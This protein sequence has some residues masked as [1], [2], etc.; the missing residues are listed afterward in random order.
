MRGIL[1]KISKIENNPI[2]FN[3]SVVKEEL[4]SIKKRLADKNFRLAIVGEFSSGKSTFINALIGKD[5]LKHATV[6]TTATLT[7][8]HNVKSDYEL[9][10]KCVV[11]FVKGNKKVLDDFEELQKYTTTISE[12][13]V[14]ENIDSV[15]LYIHFLDID[16]ELTIVDTPGL[17]GVADKHRE[18][19]IDE[20]HKAHAC[21][22][23]CQKNGIT[24]SDKS[25]IELL[26]NYQ[27]T[28]IFVQ[29]FAD[30][31]RKSENETIGD[32][33]N[34]IKT[35]IDKSMFAN[36]ELKINYSVFGISALKALAGKDRSIVKLYDNDIF[37]L[38]DEQR[39]KLLEQ[40]NIKSVENKIKDLLLSEENKIIRYKAVCHTI[41]NLLN[42]ITSKEREIYELNNTLL[43]E[44]SAYSDKEKALAKINDIEEKRKVIIEKLN[45][46]LISQFGKKETLLTNDIKKKINS[47]YET[48]SESI[49]SE[50]DYDSFSR[51]YSSGEYTN[52]LKKLIDEYKD[53]LENAEYYALQDIYKIM[54]SRLN[55]YCRYSSKKIKEFDNVKL[56]KTQVNNFEEKQLEKTKQIELLKRNLLDNQTNY[57]LSSEN[58]Q[59]LN[60]RLK[61]EENK[62]TRKI[63]RLDSIAYEK[64][65]SVNILG[66]RPEQEVEY[67]TETYEKERTG[68]FGK[69]KGF[70]AGPEICTRT[71]PVYNDSKGVKWDRE[72]RKIEEK[73]NNE[74]T[75]IQSEL[76]VLRRKNKDISQRLEE[77]KLN[78]E[79]S[80]RQINFLNNQIEAKES[81]L[82]IYQNKAKKEYLSIRKKA[83]LNDIHRYLFDENYGTR[84]VQILQNKV[85]EDMNQNQKFIGKEISNECKK[86]ITEEIERL[87][88]IINNNTEELNQKYIN[89]EKYIKQLEEQYDYFKGEVEDEYL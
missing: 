47:I 42:H 5:I 53:E 64:N 55:E 24:D 74:Y 4:N 16:E 84:I 86:Y 65:N 59:Q 39:I 12:E 46:L 1:E 33:I 45:N 40:S 48:I 8:I 68:I 43:K 79:N 71:V 23:L 18:V 80:R 72:K 30:E 41:A 17:N 63:Q 75:S 38:T 20:I 60:N 54:L 6:E 25:F 56:S 81:E 13:R 51:R 82:K 89:N 15:E 14:V 34:S 87:N 37:D 19:T 49:Q 2:I 62:L 88:S 3:N 67:R 70:F 66:R 35:Y 61:E 27:N 85:K 36:K 58:M 52:T 29:N 28:F 77:N 10:G 11:N 7:Y 57:Q 69:I 32:K 9:C 31:L 44:E 21:I 76:V 78:N 73:Y 22:Y 50:V 83:L 26:Y